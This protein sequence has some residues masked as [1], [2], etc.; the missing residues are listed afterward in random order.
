MDVLHQSA[1]FLMREAQKRGD[2]SIWIT[3]F[4]GEPL[5]EWDLL[6]YAV[7]IF[8]EKAPPELKVRFAI[9]T[10]GTLLDEKKILWM[11]K[12]RFRIFLSLDGPESVQDKLRIRHNGGGSFHAILPWIPLLLKCDCIVLKVIDPRTVDQTAESLFW[13][14]EQGFRNMTSAIAYNDLWT[15]E[16][17]NTLEEQYEKFAPYWHAKMQE[18]TP[19]YFGTFHDKIRHV[20][21]KTTCKSTTCHIG[22]GGV[23]ISIRGNLYPCSRFVDDESEGQWRIGTVTNG[24]IDSKMKQIDDYLG[25]DHEECVPCSLKDRC[26]GNGCACTNWTAQQDIFSA[27]P[28]VCFHERLVARIADHWGEV[29]LNRHSES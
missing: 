7:K 13:I 10:N 15:D 16:H 22:R 28:D 24:F 29:L 12:L 11:Q 9:N 18:G 4:G 20:L 2:K 25:R 3:F 6:K 17:W 23:A 1:D 8:Q 26:H 19:F 14:A 5:V 21:E 27:S